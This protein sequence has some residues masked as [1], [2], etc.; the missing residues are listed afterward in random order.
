MLALISGYWSDQMICLAA[1][2]RRWINWRQKHRRNTNYNQRQKAKRGIKMHF[3]IYVYGI[4]RCCF[5]SACKSFS[6]SVCFFQNTNSCHYTGTED[7]E[8]I[9]LLSVIY[10]TISQPRVVRLVL[11]PFSVVKP[12]RER[13]NL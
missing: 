3:A 2:L 13:V 6:C 11:F 9:D 8:L 4:V 10:R 12:K 7:T 5:A 1:A